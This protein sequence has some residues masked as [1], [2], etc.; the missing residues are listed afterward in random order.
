MALFVL[1]FLEAFSTPPP[2]P[3]LTFFFFGNESLV[4]T[5]M[6]VSVLTSPP[7]N[8]EYNKQIVPLV[9][10]VNM[11]IFLCLVVRVRACVRLAEYDLVR[12]SVR[13]IL[14]RDLRGSRTESYLV[15]F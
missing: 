9:P 15:C 11:L 14:C 3:F 13:G 1:F 2:P 4:F 12:L 5:Y 10:A 7:P 6:Y 8:A